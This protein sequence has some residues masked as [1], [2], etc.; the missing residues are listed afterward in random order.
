MMRPQ[1]S[2]MASISW[3]GDQPR[4]REGEVYIPR[5]DDV[6]AAPPAPCEPCSCAGRSPVQRTDL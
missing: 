3:S 4:S 5:S 6:P 2:A 1:A